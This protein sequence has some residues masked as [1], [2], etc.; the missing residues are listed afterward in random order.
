MGND[1]TNLMVIFSLLLLHF[2]RFLTVSCAAR[3]LLILR[4]SRV[5]S[6]SL[7]LIF[8]LSAF[9]LFSFFFSGSPPLD[10]FIYILG[11][12]FL[13][14]SF[15]SIS[16]GTIFE[17]AISFFLI[18]LSLSLILL[19]TQSLFA[20][21]IFSMRFLSHH[22]RYHHF[23]VVL[24]VIRFVDIH[25]LGKHVNIKKSIK[26]NYAKCHTAKTKEKKRRRRIK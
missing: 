20:R 23:M 15:I 8:L 24:Y 21:S 9:F 11:L 16:V 2:F 1:Q 26:S 13:C 14:V 10:T 4:W 6:S 22:Y 12:P 3:L 18:F 7:H 19:L 25:L 5:F 17:A